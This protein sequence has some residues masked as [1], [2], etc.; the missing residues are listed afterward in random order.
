MTEDKEVPVEEPTPVP[1]EEPK[2]AEPFK[3]YAT[4]EDF[5]AHKA[6]MLE[7]A[8][9]DNARLRKQLGAKESEDEKV[10]RERDEA[11]DARVLAAEEQAQRK[12]ELVAEFMEMGASK[13]QAADLA[14]AT[15]IEWAD[16]KEAAQDT[17]RNLSVKFDDTTKT[18]VG[19]GGGRNPDPAGEP[20][21]TEDHVAEMMQKHG[22]NW[23][24]KERRAK[25]EAHRAARTPYRKL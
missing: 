9:K 4:K 12:F 20:E 23:L 8:E 18:V 3:A 7:A 21:F 1:V 14:R 10:V 11:T 19:G 13:K 17:I 24:T 6:K 22:S 15:G 25:L 16:P 5:E 2:A